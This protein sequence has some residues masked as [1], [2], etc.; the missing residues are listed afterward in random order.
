M[1]RTV[2]NGCPACFI[3]PMKLKEIKIIICEDCLNGIGEECHTP[4]CALFLHT[5][6]LPIDK[7]LYTV[8][9]EFYCAEGI[10][11]KIS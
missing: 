6:D 2:L 7:R 4:G 9:K 1:G 5:V 11:V 3:A 8:I 10:P